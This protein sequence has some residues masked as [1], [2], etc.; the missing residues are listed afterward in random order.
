MTRV[1]AKDPTAG[2]VSSAS[3]FVRPR[4]LAPGDRVAVVAPAG[5]LERESLDAGLRVL[6]ERY[7]V[8]WD[9]GLL[10]RVRYLAGDDGRR[11]GELAAALADPGIRGI[12]AARGGD[13]SA[14]R[15]TQGG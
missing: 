8:S 9:P 15:P 10:S 12:G 4:A 13:G 2:C 1:R 6:G 3:R 7:E 5:P 11:G 14:G